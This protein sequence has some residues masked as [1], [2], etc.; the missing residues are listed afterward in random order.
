MAITTT[1][2]FKKVELPDTVLLGVG[3]QN[4]NIDKIDVMATDLDN[5]KAK[6][7]LSGSIT[8]LPSHFGDV[9]GEYSKKATVPIE[10]ITSADRV[11]IDVVPPEVKRWLKCK[12]C[13][14]IES[15]DGGVYIYTDKAPDEEVHATYK[16][17]I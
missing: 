2:G 17:V 3:C 1:N 7:A 4:E 5:L 15:Y 16:V 6:S 13:Q 8:I 14:T 12:V 10:G 9:E 11:D